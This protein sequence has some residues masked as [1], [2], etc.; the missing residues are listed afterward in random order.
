MW[1]GGIRLEGRSHAPR[2]SWLTGPLNRSICGPV[3]SAM[4]TCWLR[5]LSP[6]RPGI[7]CSPSNAPSAGTKRF[8]V[9]R[10]HRRAHDLRSV[11][12]F[13]L[14]AMVVS[15][16]AFSAVAIITAVLH[17]DRRR[18]WSLSVPPPRGNRALGRY[19]VTNTNLDH[20]AIAHKRPWCAPGAGGGSSAAKESR[21]KLRPANNDDR[22]EDR[23]VC[24]P[25]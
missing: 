23:P 24:V 9:R 4:R 6:T 17:W 14:T 21:S 7:G 25:E 3:P 15:A 20:P 19:A 10:W 16:L 2:W 8:Y 13:F 5:V 18:H 11:P 1:E 12:V 22:N